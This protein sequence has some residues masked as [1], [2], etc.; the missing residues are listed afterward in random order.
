MKRAFAVAGVLCC[1][2]FAIVSAQAG[3]AINTQATAKFSAASVRE[4]D[5]KEP[6]PS[7]VR[8][9]LKG[10]VLITGFTL[11]SLVMFAYELREYEVAGGPSWTTTRQYDITATADAEVS[12]AMQREM[13]RHLLSERFGLRTRIELREQSV[14]V[15]ARLRPGGE[16]GPG[17]RP[18]AAD[19]TAPNRPRLS[20]DTKPGPN[21]L[22]RP[23]CG[24][25]VIA[26]T[27]I[28]GGLDGDRL[29]GALSGILRR[30]VRNETGLTGRYD[31]D[32]EWSSEQPTSIAAGPAAGAALP[33]PIFAAVEE[34][35][36]LRLSSRE[37]K[38][39][40]LM[41]DAAHTPTE[42]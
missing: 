41:I 9:G 35:L 11:K 29:A 34:Q 31:V 19:C 24:V 21:G 1:S 13:L 20:P 6:G 38:L 25:M 39:S 2:L 5:P 37:E 22:R 40:V 33:T 15:L 27:L 28:A 16:G 23:P 42:N 8:E 17:L 26:N 36:G 7:G 3:R 4:S 14:Y 10:R 18:A 30:P 32:L 12:P